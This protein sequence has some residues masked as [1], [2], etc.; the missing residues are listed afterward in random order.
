VDA[1][2][3][4]PDRDLQHDLAVANNTDTGVPRNAD[5]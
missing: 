4:P 5:R 3:D 2:P 1:L